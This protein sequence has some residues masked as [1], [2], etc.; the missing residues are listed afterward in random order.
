MTCTGCIHGKT[1][2]RPHKRTVHKA[3]IGES[4][5]SDVC[6]PIHP[7]SKHDSRYFLTVIDMH[8]RYIWVFCLNNR[9]QVPHTIIQAIDR[10]AT[11]NGEQPRLLVTD[12]AKEY[13]SKQ[14]QQQ[15]AHR[16]VKY[17]PT[18]PKQVQQQLAHRG[19]KYRPTTPYTPQE[20]ALAE[21]INRTLMDKVRATLAHSKLHA[22]YW[23]DALHD[24]VFKYNITYHHGVKGIPHTL[25]YQAKPQVKKILAFGQ[26][27]FTPILKPNMP[28]LHSKAT[29]VRYMYAYDETHICVQNIESR[30]YSKMRAADFRAYHKQSDPCE[31]TNTVYRTQRTPRKKSRNTVHIPNKIENTTVAPKTLKQAQ[32]YPDADKWGQAHDKELDQ[33]DKMQAIDWQSQTASNSRKDIIPTTMTYR[34]KRDQNGTRHKARCSIRGDRMTPHKHY[35]PEKTA[36]YM[37]DRSTIRT[38]FAIAASY[39]MQIEH[40]DITGAYLH[41]TYQHNRKVFVWQPKRFDGSYKH[42]ASHGQLKGN[43]YGTPAA[44]NIY[45]TKLHA[46]LKRHGYLQMRS[47]TSLFTKK[48]GKHRI[49]VGIS[50]DDFLPIATKKSLIDELYTILQKKYTVKRMGRPTSYLNWKIRHTKMGIHIS[51]PAHIDSVVTLLAQAGCNKRSTPYLDGIKMDPHADEEEE[52]TDITAIYGKAIGEIRYIADSA[53]PDVAFA[54]TALARALKKPT[55]R[56]WNMLQRLVQYL[57]STK[58]EGI[59]MPAGKR[60]AT[61]IHAYSDADFA[62][63]ETSRKSITG[64]ITLVNGAPVQWLAKQQPVVAKSTCEAEYIAAAETTAHTLWLHNLVRELNLTAPTPTLHV[65]NT[66]AVQR[67]KSMGATKRRKCIDVRY[68]FLHDTVQQGKLQVSRIPSADQYADILTKPLKNTLYRT[69]KHNIAVRNIKDTLPSRRGEC[70]SIQNQARRSANAP[71]QHNKHGSIQIRHSYR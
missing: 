42:T 68:H 20:N 58:D 16:G 8:T 28:K 43:V 22:V 9:V 66:A 70:G 45:S 48:E 52:R 56:H 17:R 63:D 32:Q 18:N 29:Q 36:T 1:A 54:A 71:K 7:T 50:M 27:G 49:I 57:H 15:L 30:R 62:N 14:V 19:V 23:Q 41:E 34:Y 46:H 40:F 24:A 35:D 12:N 59:L 11:E 44:A 13:L 6:G 55:K 64:M 25:W 67:A 38:M 53:R 21:R 33:L 31:N 69:H 60:N 10:I 4:L 37:A 65:D 47:D 5:S 39:N 26:L 51:Q 3:N 2:T 61:M